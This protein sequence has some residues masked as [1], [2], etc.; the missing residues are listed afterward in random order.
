MAVMW[1]LVAVGGGVLLSAA[2]G[3]TALVAVAVEAER[4]GLLDAE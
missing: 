1:V 4:E 2:T 3:V